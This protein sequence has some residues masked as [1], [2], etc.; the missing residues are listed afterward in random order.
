MNKRASEAPALTEKG[1]RGRTVFL[2]E[3]HFGE[4]ASDVITFTSTI[5][6][7]ARGGKAK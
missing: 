3:E 5:N 2:L 7:T 6:K 1:G 4:G